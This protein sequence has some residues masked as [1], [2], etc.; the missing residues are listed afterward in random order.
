MRTLLPASQ[1]SGPHLEDGDSQG[2]F[3]QYSDPQHFED[4]DSQRSFTDKEVESFLETWQS[5]FEEQIGEEEQMDEKEQMDEEAKAQWRAQQ[6]FWR[7]ADIE[8][9]EDM[10][11]RFKTRDLRRLAFTLYNQEN[12]TNEERVEA[13]FRWYA[14][15]GLIKQDFK[16][17]FSTYFNSLFTKINE[18]GVWETVEGEGA[19]EGAEEVVEE[20]EEESEEE[21]EGGEEGEGMED[22][23]AVEEMEEEEEVEE[24]AEEGMEEEGE[25]GAEEGVEE[26]EEEE[27]EEEVE[28]EVDDD[29]AP[30]ESKQQESGDHLPGSPRDEDVPDSPLGKHTHSP[31]H[32]SDGTQPETD[33]LDTIR[34]LAPAVVDGSSDP[35]QIEKLT[36]LIETT[37]GSIWW[38]IVQNDKG[39]NEIEKLC[40]S[41]SFRKIPEKARNITRDGR[42]LIAMYRDP[43][44][45]TARRAYLALFIPEFFRDSL[46]GDLHY[47]DLAKFLN[48][49]TVPPYSNMFSLR[50]RFLADFHFARNKLLNEKQI[51]AIYP[52]PTCYFVQEAME[53]LF[54]LKYVRTYNLSQE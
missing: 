3:S 6:E 9:E 48:S 38:R 35:E 7:K 41:V 23:G 54:L 39:I 22:D 47:A 43:N 5:I 32:E 21:E 10:P 1:D 53:G 37:K 12:G 14:T 11:S 2:G 36:K 31:G 49:Y 51:K 25:E 24:R 44:F 34:D 42:A 27:E 45:K 40:N 18:E 17:A 8:W 29:G 19:E 33:G 4:G 50:Q 46:K 20:E 26:E 13:V 30:S 28:E 52:E 16:G 15:R